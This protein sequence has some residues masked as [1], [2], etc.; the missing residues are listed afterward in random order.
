MPHII[1][2]R[3]DTF[4]KAVRLAGYRSDYA[5]AEAMGVNRSTISRVVSGALRPGSGFIAGALAV[6]AP[7]QFDD[8]FE[9]V[10]T[11]GAHRGY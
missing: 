4:T 2:L 5:L 7:M 9:V 10:T 1:T 6:L 3:T 11:K 8:L